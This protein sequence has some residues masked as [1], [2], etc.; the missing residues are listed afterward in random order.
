[1][2]HLTAY[3]ESSKKTDLNPQKKLKKSKMYFF[4]TFLK[5]SFLINL[6]NS[7][8]IEL[9]LKT[10]IDILMNT[11][12]KEQGLMLKWRSYTSRAKCAPA[13]YC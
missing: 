13:Q 8:N 4:S 1:M 9:C 11:V 2:T 12:K 7:K 5:S 10:Y 6:T 3:P